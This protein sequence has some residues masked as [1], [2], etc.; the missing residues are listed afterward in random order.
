MREETP[1]GY[2]FRLAAKDFLYAPSYRHGST[3][4]SLCYTR[5]AALA[6]MRKKEINRPT[7][8]DWTDDPSHLKWDAVRWDTSC[9]WNTRMHVCVIFTL[10]AE[11]KLIPDDETKNIPA[12]CYSINWPNQNRFINF[13]A[14]ALKLHNHACTISLKFIYNMH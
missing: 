14:V 2:S 4:H 13:Y 5:Y 11:H 1:M 7:R 12:S 9:S 6:E 3:Y 10:S 8:R